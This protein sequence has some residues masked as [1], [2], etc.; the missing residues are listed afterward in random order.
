MQGNKFYFDNDA[1]VC[2]GK[3]R[4]KR[5]GDVRVG[6]RI[7][8]EYGI[9]GVV[10]KTERMMRH[11]MMRVNT[12]I[13]QV[14][15]SKNCEIYVTRGYKRVDMLDVTD[16]YMNFFMIGYF[17]PGKKPR[18]I[19]AETHCTYILIACDEEFRESIIVNNFK[20]RG[21]CIDATKTPVEIEKKEPRKVKR[22]GVLPRTIIDKV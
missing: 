14:A 3:N 7:W 13:V 18:T 19:K 15:V 9:S 10:A 22:I 4:Y 6:D 11:D 17:L 5:V 8:I 20:F 21:N 12:N 16:T 1:L 2:M